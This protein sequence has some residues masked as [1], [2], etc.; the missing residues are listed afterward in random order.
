MSDTGTQTDTTRPDNPILQAALNYAW[1]GL[2]WAATGN[3]GSGN[4][5]CYVFP[6]G[7]D[8]VPCTSA[9]K[10]P[11]ERPRYGATRNQLQI[12]NNFH[13]FPRANIGIETGDKICVV[14]PDTIEGHPDLKP[15]EGLPALETLIAEMGDWPKTRIARTP[16][17]GLHY[18]FSIPPGIMIKGGKLVPGVEI[19]GYG[20]Y[21]VAPPSVAPI[22]KGSKVLGTYQ[23]ENNLPLAP[24]PQWLI[25]RCKVDQQERFTSDSDDEQDSDKVC[26]ALNAIRNDAQQ[27]YDND[28]WFKIGLGAWRGS[29]DDEMVWTAFNNFSARS[30]KKY[31]PSKT[32]KRWKAFRKSRNG[33]ITVATLYWYADQNDPQWRQKAIDAALAS[34]F[35]TTPNT[36]NV[37]TKTNGAAPAT[38][39]P[40]S[41]AEE[42]NRTRRPPK[43]KGRGEFITDD[44]QGTNTGNSDT[45][46]TEDIKTDGGSNGS[47]PQPDAPDSAPSLSEDYLALQFTKAHADTLR[48]VP[49]WGKWLIWDGAK[50]SFDE[51]LK[52]YT[53]ARQICRTAAKPINKKKEGKA[54]ASAKT[55]SAVISLASA[56]PC[57][58]ASFDQW[59]VDPWLL[60]TPGGVI[61]LRTGKLRPHNAADYMTKSTAVTPNSACPTP[62]WKAFLAVVTDNDTGLQDYLRRVSGYGLTGVTIEHALYFLYGTGRNGKGVFI[63]TV[64]RI[65]DDYHKTAT[66]E[67]FT[68]STNERHPADLAMLRGARLVTV[69]ETEQGKRWSE[70]RIKTLTG[71]DP[72]TARFM[73]QDFFTY[74][75]QFK[76][77]IS[78]QHRPRLNAV[79]EAIRS[80]V[81]MVPFKV[82]I[83][84]EKRDT[85]L[86]ENLKA[87]WPG[88]LAWMIEGCLEWQRD[89]LNPPEIVTKATANY[90]ESEDKLGRWI[91]DRCERVQV[92]T[93]S[94]NLFASWKSW[95]EEN[96][97]YVVG[98]TQFSTDM[99]DAGF[100]YKR[101]KTGAGFI[102]LRLLPRNVYDDVGDNPQ[103]YTG[104]EPADPPPAQPASP[105][106]RYDWHVEAWRHYRWVKNNPQKPF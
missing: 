58:A 49:S 7:R 26:A 39:A 56:D 32:W 40:E 35:D 16:T 77:M 53:M 79:N 65:L 88:I 36:D 42:F 86:T 45:A 85:K 12:R 82:T 62:L 90:L 54:I 51:K 94:S 95:A 55:R 31:D 87:E 98:Q 29:I 34:V 80:R 44:P 57:H 72:I 106:H 89:G 91:S 99:E 13:K 15:G 100:E 17:G 83:A 74:M 28:D 84:K 9:A 61:D 69:S 59:D 75:P 37:K 105:P 66:L 27:D 4:C 41:A 3:N 47:D 52:A 70:S 101:R 103:G 67:T 24:M 93:S 97:E 81:N 6:I 33:S 8:K 25:D 5:P 76:L 1:H 96:N 11:S 43:I 48:Y 2:P 73:R 102:G 22:A 64:S 21:V 78:G 18:Y 38:D 19:L 23:W 14:D 30:K 60:N 63:N 92:W 10:Y 50:W 46:D 68:V 71:G 20:N 104:N